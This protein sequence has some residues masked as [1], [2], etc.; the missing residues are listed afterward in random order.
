MYKGYEELRQL[1][2]SAYLD[3]V[4]FETGF[5]RIN[6]QHAAEQY[7][8]GKQLALHNSTVGISANG[9]YFAHNDAPGYQSSTSSYEGIGYHAHTAS[10]L[11]GMLDY[12]RKFVVYRWYPGQSIT[13]TV[14]IE[15][16]D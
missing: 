3:W 11:R 4:K 9:T 16:E 10:L 14:L 15:R 2:A 8:T 7:E 5:D 6:P 12:A 1:P 13:E